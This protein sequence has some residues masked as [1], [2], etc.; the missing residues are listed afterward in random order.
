MR[1]MCRE[2]SNGWRH[3]RGHEEPRSARSRSITRILAFG[4]LSAIRPGAVRVP[5]VACCQYRCPFVN[6]RY[7]SCPWLLWANPR[8]RWNCL[9]LP[10]MRRPRAS[11]I[12]EP[13][14]R[15]TRQ[16]APVVLPCRRFRTQSPLERIEVAWTGNTF[17]PRSL[18]PR[19]LTVWEPT[20]R[21][22]RGFVIQSLIQARGKNHAT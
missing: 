21:M 5:N 4:I 15:E 1:W 10:P 8:F 19:S 7:P 22:S 11:L 2:S 12:D 13:R 17:W 14:S 9:A 18:W 6:L 16:R 20:Y 3:F